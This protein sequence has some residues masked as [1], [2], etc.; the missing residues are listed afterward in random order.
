MDESATKKREDKS[1][2]EPENSHI[3]RNGLPGGTLA[4]AFGLARV[5]SGE[6]ALDDYHGQRVILAFSD[7]N[8]GPC[9]Q[10]TPEVERVHRSFSLKVV[11]SMEEAYEIAALEVSVFDVA[12][13]ALQR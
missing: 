7:L 12:S 13:T 3:N 10:L 11:H 1:H 4:P 8:C 5:D 6:L 2:R 9:N